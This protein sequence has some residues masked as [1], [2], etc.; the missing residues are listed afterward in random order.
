PK[1]QKGKCQFYE[2]YK[3]SYLTYR[4]VI[5]NTR[6]MGFNKQGKPMRHS[7]RQECFNFIK[8]NPHADINHH[9]SLVNAG[10]G[11]MDP[12]DAPYTVVS[13]KRSL[14][15][16][17]MKNSLWQADSSR[18]I[19]HTMHRYRHLNRWKMRQGEKIPAPRRRHQSRLIIEANNY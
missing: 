10:V 5:N 11:G 15:P 16:R 18:E 9:N 12:R 17:P 19:V 13:R 7:G 2:D 3:G 14:T 4:S 6:F 1:K 8:Y